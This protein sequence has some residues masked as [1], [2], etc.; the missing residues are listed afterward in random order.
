MLLFATL[1]VA[2]T[3][4]VARSQT[5][6]D[7]HLLGPS[8]ILPIDSRSVSLVSNLR[9]LL[10]TVTIKEANYPS[11]LKA[12]YRT[13]GFWEF[14][15]IIPTPYWHC[16]L[17]LKNVIRPVERVDSVGNRWIRLYP[18]DM[19]QP[20]VLNFVIAIQEGRLNASYLRTLPYSVPSEVSRY[21]LP[22][23]DCDP[24]TAAAQALA[25]RL[26]GATYYASLENLHAWLDTVV[27]GWTG[28]TLPPG[29]PN[30][31]AA[32]LT[33]KGVCR[34]Q[35]ESAVALARAMGIA[36]R[37]G[38]GSGH[39]LAEVW[40]P[41]VGWHEIQQYVPLE[42]AGWCPFYLAEGVDIS[43]CS[44]LLPWNMWSDFYIS[45]FL[46]FYLSNNS[47]CAET[48]VAA[49]DYNVDSYI[50]THWPGGILGQPFVSQNGA[51]A[52]EAE[53]MV[54]GAKPTV[55]EAVQSL[56]ASS[57]LDPMRVGGNGATYALDLAAPFGRLNIADAVTILRYAL[58][59]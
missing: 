59:P 32:I 54:N 24:R 22:T 55:A 58:A 7:N 25:A 28:I 23:D 37:T 51:F 8:L 13:R 45:Q 12:V 3:G 26:K 34:D 40:I 27:Y 30:S 4:T 19:E 49:R 33:T 14:P 42:N 20:V 57:G 31:D 38:R 10:V 50:A 48:S 53:V 35:A 52:V 44:P 11:D 47:T 18:T 17:Y 29:T 36:A 56:R 9:I 15:Y 46:D 6:P 2:L 39:S 1:A 16:R 41:S 43:T 21:L 5:P